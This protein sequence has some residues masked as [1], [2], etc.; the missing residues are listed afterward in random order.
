MN[1]QI[2]SARAYYNSRRFEKDEVSRITK[3]S[4]PKEH[5]MQSRIRYAAYSLVGI[6]IMLTLLLAYPDV[7]GS[8]AKAR[9]VVPPADLRAGTTAVEE[10][11]ATLSPAILKTWTHIDL[12]HSDSSWCSGDF[13]VGFVPEEVAGSIVAGYRHTYDKGKPVLGCPSGNNSVH[14]GSV[15]FDLRE[16]ASKAAPLHV[17]VQ[18]ATLH[19]KSLSGACPG[20]VL[21]G[22]ADWVSGY[23][24]DLVPGDPLI[25]RTGIGEG[26]STL[27]PCGTG[28]C[29]VDV[30]T[31][32]NNWVR[33]EEHG[34]Y[35]NY[36]FVIKGSKEADLHWEDNDSCLARYGDFSLTVKYTYDKEP[37]AKVPDTY[38]LVCRGTEALK[39]SDV[40]GPVGFRWVGFT[41]I[42]GTKPAND[43][44]LPG[45]CSW[46]DRGM[47]AGE[48][49]RL[50]QPI[51]DAVAWMKDLNSPDSYW[52]FSVYNA[53]GQLQATRAERNKRILVPL[54]RTNFAL[55]ANG[56]VATAS[57]VYP[58]PS[59]AASN[60]NDGD[61]KGLSNWGSATPTFPQWLQI[62]FAGGKSIAEIDVFN[63]QDNY[64]S[65]AEPTE[66][67]TFSKYGLTRFDVQYWNGKFGTWATIP[68]GSVSGNNLVWRHFKFDAIT[69]SKI[70]ILC[71]GSPDS[72]SRIAEVEAWGK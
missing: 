23:S 46:Q 51:E 58:A 9:A 26:L 18:S 12:W 52:T 48:P 29:N 68:G 60:A 50:A 28:G 45:Q 67:M 42:P 16:I 13:V 2:R 35:P 65:P 30:K 47:R 25:N 40:D 49:G 15:W 36:G 6:S 31:V 66:T 61:R 43:G 71:L 20:D 11:N 4:H 56:G 53:G 37:A 38:P 22:T 44:L 72:Y 1:P 41:F 33:G 63:T 70:R 62:D 14:R 5:Y 64:L 10:G 21:V 39:V 32:V 8:R 17:S 69:T 7:D 57:S 59:V 24:G 19:F 34:G 27:G 3:L 54:L 55:A